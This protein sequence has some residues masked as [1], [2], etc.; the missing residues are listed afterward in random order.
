M[1]VLLVSN[2]YVVTPF[3]EKLAELA[4]QPEIDL[5]LI[6]PK[7]W[8]HA[9]REIPFSRTEG[10]RGYKT[11]NLPVYFNGSNGKFMFPWL[12][13]ARIFKREAPHIL[14]IEQEPL[15]LSAFQLMVINRLTAKARVVLFKWENLLFKHDPVR[16]FVER[17]NLAHADYLIAGNSDAEKILKLKGV[18][19]NR[20][21]ILP[22]V[23]VVPRIKEDLGSFKDKER[24]TIGFVGRLVEEKGIFTLLD[25]FA[26]LPETCRLLVIGSGEAR[27]DFMRGAELSGVQSRIQLPGP[28]PHEHVEQYIKGMDV[29]V[30]PSQ[31][32]SRWAEQFGH[33]LIEAMVLGIPVVGSDSGA[34]PEVIADAGLVFPEGNARALAK[35]LRKLV[36]N[37]ELGLELGERGRARCLENYTHNQIVKKTCDIY[38][39]T[40]GP[41]FVQPPQGS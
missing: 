26:Q 1:R 35:H 23:G 28:V 22:Q 5:T 37:P 40:L 14:H 11:Y 27:E 34:I 12:A 8:R 16:R 18:S 9:L 17:Y 29:L 7:I 19:E 6:V 31:T 30:L 10:D 4:A 33:V 25:A 20:I 13:L 15:S 3:R 2:A 41:G 36:E 39:S 24:F 38:R 21:E 32:T